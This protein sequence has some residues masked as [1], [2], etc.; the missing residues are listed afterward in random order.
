MAEQD[1]ALP[2]RSLGNLMEIVE[3]VDEDIGG[4]LVIRMAVPRQIDAD[5]LAALLPT[6][7]SGMIPKMEAC[8]GAVRAGVPRATVIDGR[9][10]H[11]L[12]LE[13]FTDDG[14]GTMVTSGVAG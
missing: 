8:L 10:A 2:V 13:I 9:V 12:L 4:S 1:E 3:P 5:Q 7:A 6:L 14:I 11:S